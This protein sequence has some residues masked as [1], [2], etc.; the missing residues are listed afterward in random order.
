MNVLNFIL[1]L[2]PIL[3]LIIAMSVL[4]MPGY[5]A[6]LIALA[7]T[8]A[9][10]LFYWHQA[11]LNTATATL[12]GVLNAFWPIII[13]IIAALFTYNLTLK[14]GA[15][16]TIK[17]M[18]GSVSTDKR[19]LMLIIAWGFGNFMEGMAGFGTA[20]A[21][22][23]GI[24][25]GLGFDPILSIVSCLVINST[26]TAFGSVG[27]PATTM[28]NMTGLNI[29]EI[30]SSTAIMQMLLTFAAPFLGVII[31]G[32]GAKALKGLIP[33]LLIASVSFIIPQYI[34]AA[35]I[36][37]E[38]PNIIGSIISMA[39]MIA[40][41][42]LL[43]PKTPPEFLVENSDGAPKLTLGGSLKAWSPFILI[44]IFLLFSSPLFPF[45]NGPLSSIKT[46]ASFYAGENPA[47]LTFYWINT[48]GVLILLAGFIGGLIQGAS[49]GTMFGVLGKTI[50]TNVK[51][52]VTICSVLSVAKIM[53]YSGMTSDIASVLVAVTGS[54]FPLISPL[55][56]VIGGFVT[57][58][59]T[60]TTVLFGSLQV[61]T[62][63]AIGSNPVWLAAANLVGAGIGKMVCPQS[64]A[65][66]TAAV[67]ISGSESKV[68]SKVAIFCLIF[69]VLAGIFCF[70]LPL[71][72]IGG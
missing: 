46:S 25:V 20:V 49:F 71:L 69:A 56:G 30:C 9:L 52:I 12:E 8:A 29:L 32:K 41:A 44:F 55:I 48:P 6:C 19:V 7:L 13:V 37:S 11:P 22:P 51:T 61:Q 72:G 14:T 21:I 31:I 28:A 35:F 40:A 63:R 67:G 45:I 5:R 39:V 33:F 60:S 68:L 62:A 43:P 1:A 36:G 65:I 66:G 15:M 53:G 17:A 70:T 42:K 10:A 54:M 2:L 23:A 59:G 50:K 64:I 57:G 27:V 3:W 24:L 47:T 18:L 38:L 4:K 26:P 58:S 34:A 16:E